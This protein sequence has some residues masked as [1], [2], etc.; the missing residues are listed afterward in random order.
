[1]SDRGTS[2]PST[3]ARRLD[4]AQRRAM[5]LQHAI[6]VFARR[7]IGGARHAEIARKARVA[8]PTVFFYFAT[9]K[10]LVSAVLEEVARFFV[11]MAEAAH[12]KRGPAPEVILDHLRAFADAVD[13][14]PD[15]TRILLEWSTAL[16]GETW[17]AFLKFQEKV[18]AVLIRTIR[19]SRMETGSDRDPR[20]EDDARLI[21]VT[22]YVLVQMK[23]AKLPGSRIERFLRTVV[24][25]T[26]DD[27]G[28]SSSAAADISKFNVAVG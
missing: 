14:H 15:H 25:D 12:G 17:P 7:G 20:A 22:G 5:L 1:M 4:H 10:A 23:L 11:E 2:R 27:S 13:T 9:R 16:R 28:A 3:R 24:R 21:A 18:I 8:V 19:R 6:R 26:L